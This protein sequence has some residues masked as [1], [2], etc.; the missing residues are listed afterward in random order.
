MT[1]DD[2]GPI[3][4]LPRSDWTDQDLLTKVEARERLVE[5]IA[6]TWVRLDQ[7]RAGTGDSAE[8]ALLE[9]RLNAMESIR[10]EYND[11]LGGT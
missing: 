8:I 1:D 9:R 7:A 6:R 11:Y 10:N 5:E 4:Q 3:E 2:A